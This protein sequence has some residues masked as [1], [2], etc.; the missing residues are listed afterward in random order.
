MPRTASRSG[1]PIKLLQLLWAPETKVGRSGTTVAEVLDQAIDL[2]SSEGLDALTMRRLATQVGVGAMTLYGYV[3]G[4]PE[5][6][7]LMLDKAIART[8]K[9]HQKPAQISK[10]PAALR[11]VATRNYEHALEHSWVVE[12]PPAR[13][14]LGPGHLLKYEDELTPLDGIG[15]DDVAM[16]QALTHILSVAQHAARWEHAIQQ[17]R[18]TSTLT[19]DQ[20]W[21]SVES[22][23]Y[24][25]LGDVQLPVSNRVGQ[26]LANA[27]DPSQFLTRSVDTVIAD[28]SRQIETPTA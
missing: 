1:D 2:A 18:A 17:A 11:H 16:D 28:V 25:L 13:P 8:Y 10:W 12:V 3:P 4:K 20:W 6:L 27:G 26:T 24:T 7:E 21:Y 5:L 23:L 9:G 15:L 14:I 19:D 22:S